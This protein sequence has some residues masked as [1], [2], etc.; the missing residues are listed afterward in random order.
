MLSR[1]NSGAS[2][3]ILADMGICIYNFNSSAGLW[4][5][6]EERAIDYNMYLVNRLIPAKA[7]GRVLT[8]QPLVSL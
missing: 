5:L 6:L 3:A 8:S 4:R 7:V 1:L 2:E